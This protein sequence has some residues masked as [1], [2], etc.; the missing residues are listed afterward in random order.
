MFIK[1]IEIEGFA[2]YLHKTKVSSLC[3]GANVI[4]GRNGS[5]KSNFLAALRFVFGELEDDELHHYINK[6]RSI[7]RAFVAVTFGRDDDVDFTI[8][9]TNGPRKDEWKWNGRF[10][11]AT[12]IRGRLEAIGLAGWISPFFIMP[13][14]DITTLAEVSS[15]QRL[16]ALEKAS[17][18]KFFDS[19]ISAGYSLLKETEESM[20]DIEDYA[21]KA[22][23]IL[24]LLEEEIIDLDKWKRCKTE[25]E[26]LKSLLNEWKLWNTT[27]QLEE[28]KTQRESAKANLEFLAKRM[29]ATETDL[30]S[31]E[32]ALEEL[33]IQ[34]RLMRTELSIVG[35]QLQNIEAE[36]LAQISV[37]NLERLYER[38]VGS[39]YMKDGGIHNFDTR[40]RMVRNLVLL[41]ER[42]WQV[43]QD[44]TEVILTLKKAKFETRMFEKRLGFTEERMRSAGLFKSQEI[45][46]LTRVRAAVQ[47]LGLEDKY[48]GTLGE[49]IRF[50]SN[51][52]TAI[53]NT[54]T[55]RLLWHIV[56]DS[57]TVA[58]LRNNLTQESI[59]FKS[60]DSYSSPFLTR[61]S[62]GSFIE[63][64]EP[65]VKSFAESIF[66]E[67]NLT[68]DL[69][70]CFEKAIGAKKSCVTFGGEIVNPNGVIMGGSL[71]S[72]TTV[73][74]LREHATVS[75]HISVLSDIIKNSTSKLS[76]IEQE[77]AKCHRDITTLG[78]EVEKISNQIEEDFTDQFLSEDLANENYFK[79][80]SK[81]E[82]FMRKPKE[83]SSPG[84]PGGSPS[85]MSESRI[86]LIRSRFSELSEKLLEVGEIRYRQYEC[87]ISIKDAR[88]SVHREFFQ[89][90]HQVSRLTHRI[91]TIKEQ[92]LDSKK[93][94]PPQESPEELVE[95]I[96]QLEK[97][98]ERYSGVN[99][100]TSS[101]YSQ[102]SDEIKVLMDQYSQLKNEA[103]QATCI[104]AKT[105]SIRDETMKEFLTRVSHA[106]TTIFPLLEQEGSGKL[107]SNCEIVA[108]FHSS[109][110]YLNSNQLSGGQKVLCTIAL[111]FAFH[112]YR[113]FPFY[114]LDE[115]DANLDPEHRR[116]VANFL[117]RITQSSRTQLICTTFHNELIDI[118]SEV[119]GVI[120]RGGESSVHHISQTLAHR[121]CDMSL[122]FD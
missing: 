46:G 15:S 91:C 29:A 26:R 37:N 51:L 8:S 80:N 73:S 34:E 100:C 39:S 38:Y 53:A 93:T 116:S 17:G 6:A 52:E 74:L 58:A 18:V 105:E 13:Q 119:F 75:K 67:F 33:E 23:D 14:G 117:S 69:E 95:M 103:K 108:R 3:R 5:G 102:F 43:E 114:V 19:S 10:I 84:S 54:M 112:E 28:L 89:A 115:I 79:E 63:V 42:L 118:A 32:E 25:Q 83:E 65:A 24:Q 120:H 27:K 66:D 78:L 2:S 70:D 48:F 68:T 109:Q 31:N 50:N 20:A 64:T 81:A 113:P 99:K 21:G 72:N 16:K 122:S 96:S 36:P 7:P 71:P 90:E 41:K 104:F 22:N 88:S 101:I 92:L 47:E 62:L 97:E 11:P 9:R 110:E 87:L 49:C 85:L 12:E 86:G 55:S 44:R 30:K 59:V 107:D 57:D 40:S 1:E 77:V 56:K 76:L 106:F 60:A 94:T 98:G 4:V 45:A 61:E 35:A 82:Y 111:I 121:F